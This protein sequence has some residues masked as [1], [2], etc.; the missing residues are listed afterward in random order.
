M[1]GGTGWKSE[2]SDELRVLQEARTDAAFDFSLFQA[3]TI[4]KH[5]QIH[6]HTHTHTPAD[7]PLN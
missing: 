4:H 1:S 6:G 3:T 2:R 7:R 5:P